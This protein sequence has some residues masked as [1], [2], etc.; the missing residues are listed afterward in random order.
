VWDEAT[1]GHATAGTFGKYLSESIGPGGGTISVTKDTGGANVLR[2]EVSG[3][4][5]QNVV[6]R[7]FLTSDYDDGNR[8]NAYTKG[9]ALSD[10]D[11]DFQLWLAA[12][13][14]TI[15]YYRIRSGAT[16]GISSGTTTVTVS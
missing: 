3:V 5:Q 13:A 14:Y 1:A 2:P 8:T 9:I 10:A 11:G 12:A 6:V 7:A 16:D 4:A 15:A